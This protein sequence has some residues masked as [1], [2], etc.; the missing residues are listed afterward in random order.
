MC[1]ASAIQCEFASLGCASAT[2]QGKTE[3][4]F[5]AQLQGALAAA[6]R[7]DL[8]PVA[9]HDPYLQVHHTLLLSQRFQLEHSL[10]GS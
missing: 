5:L 9:A 10:G 2:L 1:S 4:S 3:E 6:T 8:H 7:C